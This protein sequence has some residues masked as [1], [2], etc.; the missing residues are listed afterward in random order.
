MSTPRLR[1]TARLLPLLFLL[2]FPLPLRAGQSDGRLDIIWVD[3]EGG[4]ATLIVTPAGE[5]VLVDTGYPGDRDARRIHKAAAEAGVK[6]IDHLVTTHYHLDHFGGAATLATLMPIR[7]VYD[8]GLF[9]EGWEKPSKEY[10]EFKSER[11]VVLNPGDDVPL[12]SPEKGPPLRLR[13]LAARQKFIDPPPDAKPNDDCA[14]LK[15]QRPD[16]TDNA[17]SIVLLLT[18]GDFDFYD[19][20]DLTWNR[21]LKLVCPTKLVPE[22]DA[23]QI[24]HHGTDTSNPPQLLK[25][26]SPAVAVIN[27]GPKKGGQP[28]SF[29]TLKA[30]P[31]IQ[32]IYQ[33]HR[34]VRPGEGHAN[35]D[36]TLTAN[37]DEAC[38]GNSIKLSVEPD[39]ARYH[40]T[41]PAT[42]HTRT[43]ETKRAG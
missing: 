2:T 3:V 17:N 13:C 36:A 42:G 10:L 34:N 35:T 31:S 22:V 12:K 32:A 23:F 27:N 15:R 28:N 21:E 24:T 41:I 4:A 39:G 8:N 40:V 1:V 9:K 19:G 43:F 6:Q 30:T 33:V 26:L 29:A 16:Y 11:R 7:N 18:F 37:A 38:E 20:G 25:A 5:S 14:D